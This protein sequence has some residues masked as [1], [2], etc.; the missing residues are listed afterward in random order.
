MKGSIK[1]K[2]GYIVR[3]VRNTVTGAEGYRIDDGGNPLFVA[4]KRSYNDYQDEKHRRMKTKLTFCQLYDEISHELC[5][6]CVGDPDECR[7]CRALTIAYAY[8]QAITSGTG[9]TRGRI[10]YYSSRAVCPPAGYLVA[11]TYVTEQGRRVAIVAERQY[12]RALKNPYVKAA[13]EGIYY[14]DPIAVFI[15]RPDGT[16]YRPSPEL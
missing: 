5:L 15:Q 8:A 7:A 12:K 10:Y 16:L 2:D 3:K 9:H 11:D 6:G 14:A 1:A 13:G 4:Q